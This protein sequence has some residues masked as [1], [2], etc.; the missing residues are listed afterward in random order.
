MPRPTSKFLLSLK[1]NWAPWLDHPKCSP[2]PW[3][4]IVNTC[5]T[6]NIV[7]TPNR[8]I[9]LHTSKYASF[10]HIVGDKS[11]S[12][13]SSLLH[14]T[15]LKYLLMFYIRLCYVPK[16]ICLH[17]IFIILLLMSMQQKHVY[18]VL[19]ENLKKKH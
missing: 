19:S 8:T 15:C 7:L 12:T 5:L 6:S 14:S 18:S 9:P 10:L 11:I 2:L 1:K 3:F 13:T 17:I 16:C 4:T